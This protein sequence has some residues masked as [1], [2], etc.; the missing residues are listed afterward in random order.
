MKIGI[1]CRT[2]LNP[3]LGERVGAAHYTYYLVKNLLAIDKVNKYVLFFPSTTQSS[4]VAELI[5][6][7]DNVKVKFFPLYRYKR[8]L[9][10]TYSQ[11]LVSAVYESEKLDLL[12]LTVDSL[13]YIYRG[14][15]TI[16]VHDLAI[17]KHPELFP[18]QII[19]NLNLYAKALF[20]KSLKR[21]DKIIAVSENTKKDLIELFKVP[22]E[23]IK[24]IYEGTGQQSEAE[25]QK[26][27]SQKAD[28]IIEQFKINRPYLLFLGTIEPRKNLIL[29]VK[30]FG[31]LLRNSDFFQGFQLVIAGAK[32]YRH[33]DVFREIKKVNQDHKSGFPPIKYVGYVDKTAKY[34]L[35]SRAACFVFPTLYEGFGLPIVEAMSLGTPVITSRV[36]SVPEIT[37]DSA[38]LINPT[39]QKEMTS[40]ISGLLKDKN[41]QEELRQKGF[42]QSKKFSWRK[43]ADET[44]KLYQSIC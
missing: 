18:S 14:K 11:L 27:V 30:S 40:A 24:V 16:T 12:H 28:S 21:S 38:I 5:Q 25:I 9:P 32:G 1:D 39:D 42:R 29:L 13:P 37:E 8:F 19:A 20:P 22:S 2:I 44:L 17:F 35:M 34:A 43:C 3:S 36:S 6:G 33:Q 4:V 15:S 10:L 23:K 26:I 7:K 31:D 41:L